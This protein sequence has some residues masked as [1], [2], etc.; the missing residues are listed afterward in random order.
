VRGLPLVI[1]TMAGHVA[2]STHKSPKE[3]I[4][5][6][7]TLLPESKKDR[8]SD[9]TQEEAGR[10]VSHC[11]N[12]M[13]PEIKTCSLY[14][15][16]FPKG[17]EISRKRLTRRWIAE[18]FVNEKQGLS[19]EDVAETYFNHLIRRK[20]IRP[21]QHSSNGKVKTCIV[22][23]MILE[24][25]VSKASEENFITVVGGHWLMHQPSSKVRRLSLQVS[26][27]KRA[28]DTEKM[29]LSHVRSLT[30]FENLNQLPSGSFKFGIV[31]VLDL[32]GCKG[33]KHQHINEICG[34]HLLKYLSLRGTDT[35]LLPKMIGK[36]ENLETL[37]VRGTDIVELPTAVC[38]L[39]RLVNILGGHKKTHKALKLPEELVKKKKMT[40]LRIL[41]GVEIVE[42]AVDLHH[43]IELR[44]L[45][46]YKI[47]LI[48]DEKLKELSSSIEYL[49]GYSLHT[50]IID[51]ISSKFFK[52]LSEMSSPPKFLVALELSGK[53][54]QL[55]DWLAQLESLNKLTLS[56]TALR[57]DNLS[58]LSNLK[59]LFSLT[60]TIA[61]GKEGPET[62]VILAQNKLCSDGEIVVPTGGF[63]SLKL[64]RFSAPLLPLLSFS[65]DAMPKLERIELQF[66]MLE[67]ILGT[68]NLVELKE[69]YLRLNQKHGK[70][71]A[72]KIVQEVK[73]A[74]K[75][76]DV[77][78]PIRIT[79]DH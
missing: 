31:Q 5:L 23:D 11:Y 8:G 76:I 71:M 79:I 25:I 19:V 4:D 46:I 12:D 16:I 40:A 47:N 1:V 58:H 45:S 67:G 73:S 55:P 32:E 63:E 3:W 15:S 28:K 10:I 54:I 21:V 20:I 68:E 13:P 78:K 44:K 75:R 39:E 65:E 60:F 6:C 72:E 36:L 57:T 27:S 41:S 48:D 62:L 70:F 22:H 2:C 18:G 77:Q 50:L 37:D 26:D 7:K 24:H 42:G 66:D 14:L 69:V 56:V 49:C 51:D 74:V 59:A 30:V 61:S 38:N 9:L 35:K 29:N 34:M 17:H 53:I 52:L 64:L 43:L 33:F